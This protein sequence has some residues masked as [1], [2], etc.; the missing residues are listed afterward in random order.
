MTDRFILKQQRSDTQILYDVVSFLSQNLKPLMHC[1]AI[2]AGP[3][4]LLAGLFLG[5]CETELL[6]GIATDSSENYALPYQITINGIIGIVLFVISFMLVCLVTSSYVVLYSRKA[7]KISVSQIWAMVSKRFFFALMSYIC[8]CI[9]VLF[10]LCFFI[11]PG[12]YLAVAFQFSLIIMMREDISFYELVKRCLKIVKGYWMCTL[13]LLVFILFIQIII[14]I[15]FYIP[16]YVIATAKLFN[17]QVTE[18]HLF[19]YVISLIIG[20]I[21]NSFIFMFLSL[22]IALKYFN[23]LGIQ[24][25]IIIK[26]FINDNKPIDYK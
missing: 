19:I 22:T 21:A 3:V 15:V 20:T 7:D 13:K 16:A 14:S 11:I 6:N 10:G 4:A 17:L 24:E 8:L 23:I 18:F 9:I 26:K 5:I 12:I 1:I 2:I 25:N